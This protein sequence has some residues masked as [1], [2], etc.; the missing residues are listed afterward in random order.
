MLPAPYRVEGIR[1]AL[2]TALSNAIWIGEM[3]IPLLLLWRRAKPFAWVLALALMLGIELAAREVFF[4]LMF[5][6]V[7]L[8]FAAAPIVYRA[9]PWFVGL[10]FF[11]VALSW[12][13]FAP[14]MMS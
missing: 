9:M 3:T 4:G 10:Q 13:G 8:S 2:F 6:S 14:K 1:G 7:I 12:L 11:L 5:S